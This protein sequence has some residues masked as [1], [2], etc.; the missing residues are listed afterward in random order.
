L[1]FLLHAFAGLLFAGSCIAAGLEDYKDQMLPAATKAEPGKNVTVMFIG[2][3]TLLFDDGETA[4][5]TDG[6]FSRPPQNQLRSIKPDRD[7]IARALKRA[8]VTSLAA[9]MPV[10]SHYDHAMDSP[11]VAMET[12]ALLVGSSSTANIGKG[13]GLPEA[14][15]R[16]VNAGDSATFGRFKVTFI[17]SAHLP[18]GYATGP[19]NAPVSLPAAASS[20]NEGDCFSLLIEHEGRSLLVQGSAGF[21]PGALQG[22][23]ADVVYLGIGG[24][25]TKDPAYQDAYWNEIVRAV[26]AR[27]VIPIHWDNFFR[28]LDDGLVPSSDFHGM[29]S[30]LLARSKTEGVEIRLSPMWVSADPF[31]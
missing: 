4:I 20:F 10:H 12:G 1:K 31:R 27:R 16:V 3:A 19:I 22:R 23:K 15:I 18:T 8:G 5:M 17:K 7:V 2:V 9:V 21:V 30:S 28:P 24:L 6:F 26:G 25:G 29:M 13:Y 11:I 14:R